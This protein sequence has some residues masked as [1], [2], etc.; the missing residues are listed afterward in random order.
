VIASPLSITGSIGVVSVRP[1][2]ERALELLGVRVESVA[3]GAVAEWM[4]S[5][6]RANDPERVAYGRLLDDVYARFLD[7]VARGRK[8]PLE[9]VEAAAGGRVWLASAAREHDLVDGLGAFDDALAD[10]RQQLDARSPGSGRRAELV[11]VEGRGSLAG[12]LPR[13]G[14]AAAAIVAGGA[15]LAR[16]LDSSAPVGATTLAVWPHEV[17]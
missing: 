8:L 7:A 16:W 11:W 9:R 15:V 12:W 5:H 4:P 13:P 17:D 14:T 10:V 2:V 1:V 3:R 6:R